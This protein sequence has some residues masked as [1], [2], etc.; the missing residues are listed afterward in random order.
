M[1]RSS[2][3]PGLPPP[4]YFPP[5]PPAAAA[6]AAAPPPSS[7][8]PPLPVASSVPPPAPPT[9]AELQDR[10]TLRLLIW[11]FLGTLGLV[12]TAACASS[13]HYSTARFGKLILVAV[14]V[15]GVCIACV[16]VG[17]AWLACHTY[18]IAKRAL[19]DR[20]RRQPVRLG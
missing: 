8:I 5:P 18:S 9:L 16:A 12:L 20:N 14:A 7:L 3:P 6:A 17:R 13:A 4:A 2:S 11:A 19:I 10:R 1:S 15:G